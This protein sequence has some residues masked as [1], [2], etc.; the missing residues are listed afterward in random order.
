MS[1]YTYENEYYTTYLDCGVLGEQEVEVSISVEIDYEDVVNDMGDYVWDYLHD[2]DVAK[3]VVEKYADYMPEIICEAC[4]PGLLEFCVE[5]TGKFN[6]EG[7]IEALV[8]L[9]DAVEAA[10]KQLS[11]G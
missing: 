10:I 11:D 9:K 1:Y 4:T 3:R 7:E 6:E 2:D 5:V 8:E